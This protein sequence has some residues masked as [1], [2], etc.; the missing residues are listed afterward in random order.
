M[1]LPIG[2]KL[3]RRKS[4]NSL[5]HSLIP[6]QHDALKRLL[7]RQDDSVSENA[8]VTR[9]SEVRQ[10]IGVREGDLAEVDVSINLVEVDACTGEPLSKVASQ[11]EHGLQAAR[12]GNV[13]GTDSLAGVLEGGSGPVR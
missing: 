3:F 10:S 1:F 13:R 11:R 5:L 6:S 2:V 4:T 12:R 7:L 8:I 9:R